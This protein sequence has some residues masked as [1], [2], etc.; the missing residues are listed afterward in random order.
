MM[1]P[2]AFGSFVKRGENIYRTSTFIQW[3]DSEESIGACL[4]QNPGS[5]TL[6]KELTQLLNA[7]GSASGWIKAEDPTMKQLVSVI[8]GIYGKNKPISGRLHIY[9]IFN[10]QNTKSE[11]AIDH[12][13]NLVH[14]GEYDITKPLVNINEFKLHPWILLGWGVKQEK[15]WKNFQLIKEKWLKLIKETNVPSFGKKHEKKNEYYHPC[16]LI[17]SHR[18]MMAQELINIYKQQFCIQ[19]FPSYATKPNLIVEMKQVE[20]Y[21]DDDH[22]W[23]RTPANPESIVKGFSHLSIQSG[24]KLRAYQFSDGGGNGNGIVWAIPEKKELQDVEDCKQLD[25]FLSAPKPAH[26]LSDF[27]QV[28]EGDKTPLSYLQAAIVYHE[29]HEFGANWHGTSWGRD[30]ILPV[31]EESGDESY[32]YNVNDEWEMI[33]KEPDIIEPHFYYSREGYPVI[34]FHTINDI[35]T[36]TWNRYVHVFSKDDYTLKVELTCIATGGAGIIF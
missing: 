34:V 31:Q 12:F 11:D 13:E 1:E 8:E 15:K 27:M 16:P 26:A 23:Y 21:D 17:S 22:G 35:G 18:P 3:G 9:N 4:L 30:V 2:K 32:D 14:S 24:Y 33:E 19:R 6:D 25:G 20:K 29:L 36:V 7:V 28:I 10:L 5:A